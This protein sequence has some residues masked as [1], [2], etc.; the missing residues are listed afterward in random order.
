MRITP[1]NIIV[2]V[3]SMLT[4]CHSVPL[5]PQLR[6]DHIK[7]TLYTLTID[8]PIP[9]SHVVYSDYITLTIDHPSITLASW[10]VH[11]QGITIFDKHFKKDKHVFTQAV[12]VSCQVCVDQASALSAHL[13][14]SYVSGPRIQVH[15]QVFK[16]PIFQ[17]QLPQ[18]TLTN[19]HTLPQCIFPTPA[20][21]PDTQT[22]SKN[23]AERDSSD[24]FGTGCLC[25]GIITLC[26]ALLLLNQAQQENSE[27]ALHTGIIALVIAVVIIIHAYY[28][29]DSQLLHISHTT[30]LKPVE[31]PVPYH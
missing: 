1:H 6:C 11:S 31:R 5:A 19:A 17:K 22:L 29:L 7:D 12:V 14:L 18:Q 3:W 10:K 2:I 21:N 15:H 4:S 30:Y 16:L 24:C 28:A 8:I 13:H 20:Q 25:M 26:A 9:P 23:P 27:T